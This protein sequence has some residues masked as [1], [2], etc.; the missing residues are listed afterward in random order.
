MTPTLTPRVA[1]AAK[2]DADWLVVPIAEGETLSPSVAALDSRLGGLITRLRERGDVTGKSNETVPILNLP[3][4]AAS[5]ILLLGIGKPSGLDRSNLHDAAVAAARS[6]SLKACGRIA[7]MLPDQI[8]VGAA[9]LAT[10]IGLVQGGIGPGLRK[11]TPDRFS[12][13]EIILIAPPGADVA[14]F[15]LA[16]QRAAIEGR[17]VALARELVNTPPCD[18]YPESFANRARAT[19]GP[20][21]VECTVLD[22]PALRAERMGALLGIAQG[23]D[24]PPRLVVLRYAGKKNGPTLGLVGKGVTFDSGGL[25]LKTNDQMSDMKCDMAGAAA[26]LAGV[27]A[28]AE[29]KLPVNLLGVLALVENMPSGRA[30]KL[31]DVLHSRSGKT[32]EILNTDAEGRVILADALN[33]AADQGANHLLDLATLTGACMVA[34]GASVAGLMGNDESWNGAV[35]GA[36]N[37]RRRTGL[38][39]ATLATL[40]GSD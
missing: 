28:A 39:I 14:A 34:L 35:L 32:I 23:S 33:Y 16:V 40:R 24:R 13:T 11:A 37:L 18:L 29:L 4:I 8:P 15:E 9:A 27:T 36:A 25:S 22:E 31:G 1:P 20:V 38:A 21:G 19:A 7:A 12:P 26:V 30:V 17:A 5:R 6:I 3:G 2:V 10:G